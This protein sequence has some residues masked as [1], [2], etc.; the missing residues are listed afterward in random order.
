MLAQ[1][2]TTFVFGKYLE[3]CSHGKSCTIQV[4]KI[5]FC[6]FSSNLPLVVAHFDLSRT[7]QFVTGPSL[8]H[9]ASLSSPCARRWIAV[10]ACVHLIATFHRTIFSF[11]KINKHEMSTS[12]FWNHRS[13]F[14]SLALDGILNIFS[15]ERCLPDVPSTPEV[16]E[17]PASCSSSI[18]SGSRIYRNF[19]TTSRWILTIC[20]LVLYCCKGRM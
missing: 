7:V 6:F 2:Q 17:D 13:S 12:I 4:T 18:H 3:I 5:Q 11:K 1:L 10:P 19:F 20:C 15:V 9:C 8:Y 14:V 16:W